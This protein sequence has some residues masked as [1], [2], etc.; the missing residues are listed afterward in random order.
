MKRKSL[1]SLLRVLAC[2]WHCLSALKFVFTMSIH[3][4]CDQQKLKISAKCNAT[5]FL[6]EQQS[7]LSITI[8]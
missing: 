6:D 3:P 7:R 2:T 4:I 5:T 8:T 1:N